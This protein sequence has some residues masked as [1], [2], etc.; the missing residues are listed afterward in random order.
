M[1][2]ERDKVER[3]EDNLEAEASAQD[4][5][6][7]LA[8]FERGLAGLTR[9]YEQRK[10]LH[11][12]LQARL[13]VVEEREARNRERA[14]A[15]ER[16][17]RELVRQSEEVARARSE[18]GADRARLADVASA[19]EAEA[20]SI[21]AQREAL[22]RAVA[23]LEERRRERD[24]ENERLSAEVAA[25]RD[26]VVRLRTA[27]EERESALEARGVERERERAAWEARLEELRAAGAA[28]QRRAVEL[29]SRLAEERERWERALAD[30]A[31]ERERLETRV[32]EQT[33]ALTELSAGADAARARVEELT[34]RLT[35]TEDRLR[36]AEAAAERSRA[37]VEAVEK[38][39]AHAE[40]LLQDF[41][42]QMAGEAAAAAEPLAR[43]SRE[44][45]EAAAERDVLRR[46]LGE[47]TER[48][49]ALESRLSEDRR[50]MTEA[51]EAREQELR[52]LRDRVRT[53]EEELSHARAAARGGGVAASQPGADP[54]HASWL[55]L[56]RR[57]LARYRRAIAS[58][59]SKVRKAGE[60]LQRRYEMCEQILAQ[61]AE[62]V[63]ARQTLAAAQAAIER[64]RAGGRAVGVV[65]FLVL[66][67]ATLAGASWALAWSFF[68][69]TYIASVTLRAD[70]PSRTLN[71]AELS[72]WTRYHADQLTDPQ[73]IAFAAERM[74]ARGIASLASPGA[75]TARLESDLRHGSAEP[76]TLTIE[77]TGEGAAATA[78]QLTQI[79]AA[80][81]SFA[82]DRRFTRADGAATRVEGE[83]GL[84]GPFD[85]SRL[86]GAAVI[87]AL[88]SILVLGLMIFIWHRLASAKAMF[89]G[90]QALNEILDDERW[91]DIKAA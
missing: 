78:R 32:R 17:E 70:N 81:A 2:C 59:A 9:L 29:E 74:Q 67:L 83:V 24:A 69:G 71:D 86:Y 3:Q 34:S 60:A 5:F 8:E 62:L 1:E 48:V 89:D 39:A 79:A 56:R 45:D 19:L 91:P 84:V 22:E 57:R 77:L 11:A 85:R 21:R 18:I 88:L 16:L 37:H 42:S 40:R 23:E 31:E 15:I 27:L 58:Q 50:A 26:E 80:L 41:Q 53:L 49:K 38:R 52:S 43:L 82:N 46:R 30:A 25:A 73:F 76:G 66:T 51:A 72:E 44:L 28:A 65:C 10:Q 14:E 68:P 55:E 90:E 87:F 6:R 61:R 64:R 75:L 35:Q 13:G 36:A 12:A 20:A 33:A 7:V 54:R 47:A 4:V 63:A